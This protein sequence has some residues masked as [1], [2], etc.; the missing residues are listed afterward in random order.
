MTDINNMSLDEIC[1]EMKNLKLFPHDIINI[2]KDFSIYVSFME[3][4]KEDTW[5]FIKKHEDKIDKE[6][7]VYVLTN[8]AKDY[9]IA[10]K[11][12]KNPNKLKIQKAYETGLKLLNGI[13]RT[14]PTV[15]AKDGKFVF[16]AVGSVNDLKLDNRQKNEAQNYELKK[17]EESGVDRYTLVF[18]VID[19][20][21]SCVCKSNE[22]ADTFSRILR[23]NCK[24]VIKKY[25][26]KG[27]E[28]NEEFYIDTY[29]SEIRDYLKRFPKEFNME[30]IMLL[31][32][33]RMKNSLENESE[34]LKE[35]EIKDIIKCMKYYNEN[36]KKNISIKETIQKSVFG[37]E[38]GEIQYSTEEL[39]EDFKKVIGDKYYSDI[40]LEDIKSKILNG[41]SNLSD[42]ENPQ[43][44]N[45]INFTNEEVNN[46]KSNYQ[47]FDVLLKLNH[48]S[49]EEAKEIIQ[50]NRFSIG[51]ETIKILASKRFISE[52]DIK[53][54]YLNGNISTSTMEEIVNDTRFNI[55][56]TCQELLNKY[57]EFLESREDDVKLTRVKKYGKLAKKINSKDP[58]MEEEF[59]GEIIDKLYSN[60][61][62]LDLDELYDLEILP[63]Q[64][65]ID[66]DGE[67][68]IYKLIE[69]LKL[70]SEDIVQLLKRDILNIQKMGNALV[71]SKSSKIEKIKYI[72][73]S[74]SY[75]CNTKEEADEQAIN[76]E[77][78]T[79][80]V[81][82]SNIIKDV[83]E[84][85]FLERGQSEHKKTIKLGNGKKRKEYV[86]D[87]ISRWNLFK[88][89]DDNCTVEMYND[90]TTK[91][92]LPNVNGGTVVFEKTLKMKDDV[93]VPDYAKATYIMSYSDYIKN[94]PRIE[95]QAYTSK[96]SKTSDV[97]LGINRKTLVSMYNCHQ[98]DKIIHSPAWGKRVK[99][100]LG[101]SIIN[102]YGEQK[103]NR[104]DSLINKIEKS[105]TLID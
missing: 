47:N 85:A 57:E 8:A 70:K 92:E 87:I 58:K 35:D 10:S 67:E 3:K 80:Y 45:L 71:K 69:N 56:I 29:V 26:M 33:W 93:M 25:K 98:A 2:S 7:L 15:I 91:F 43:I 40:E 73:D 6:K 89:L 27:V 51:Y 94:R 20:F 13:K 84:N 66:W 59:Y 28:E 65:L 76:A 23:Y 22:N 38:I 30:K 75:Q 50:K 41:E 79:Q 99:E 96:D 83:D 36:I 72:C 86:S 49:K 14:F 16:E 39:R 54:M 32:A 31:S 34:K 103:E 37:P 4:Y 74:F 5:D 12:F 24:K 52:N 21:S 9:L 19:E 62:E 102:L 11:N 77:S 78:L 17:M 100:K 18:G 48:I 55:E 101:G 82:M 44:Y 42:L 64:T 63:I 105:R 61:D 1:R 46:I 88:E 53:E 95:Q 104:I 68:R 90:G 81:E 97:V 60:R